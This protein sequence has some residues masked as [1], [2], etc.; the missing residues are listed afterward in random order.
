MQEEKTIRENKIFSGR[1]L[2]LFDDEVLLEN[3]KNAKR[4]YVSH[5]GGVSVVAIND[6]NEVYFVRQY[7]YPYK[8]F[9]I[10]IPAGKLEKGEDPEVA[11]KRELEEEI[12]AKAKSFEHI[13]VF[14]PSPGYTNEKIYMYLAKDLEFTIQN[15]DEDEFLEVG[16]MEIS[17]FVNLIDKGEITDGKTIAAVLKVYL[18]SL[19]WILKK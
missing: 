9:V 17:K 1:I 2:N 4:E 6:K 15:L 18:R 13:G 12:G 3:G 19:K 11:A 10:E 5:N 7:R 16:K 14:Y 8:E